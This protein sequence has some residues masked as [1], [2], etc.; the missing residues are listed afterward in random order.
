MIKRKEYIDYIKANEKRCKSDPQGLMDELKNKIGIEPY[1]SLKDYTPE[2]RESF[3]HSDG[4]I[5]ASNI[6]HI[7]D[8]ERCEDCNVKVERSE[9]RLHHITNDNY[10][11][12]YM[13]ELKTLCIPC[14]DKKLNSKNGNNGKR[15][16]VD[17]NKKPITMKESKV[18]NMCQEV[19][20][21]FEE[22][23]GK[24]VLAAVLSGELT[25]CEAYD[26]YLYAKFGEKRPDTPIGYYGA[27]HKALQGKGYKHDRSKQ[28]DNSKIAAKKSPAPKKA[29]PSNKGSN[30][31][32][33]EEL[34]DATVYLRRLGKI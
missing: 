33:A 30:R 15:P 3:Y 4:W 6:A 26:K 9:M 27:M 16:L 17:N 31:P 10:Y 34:I 13:N 32:S 25:P 5:C 21:Y 28:A 19:R 1:Q 12:L 20:N 22:E 14:H 23:E 11:G 8:D 24:S 2:K 18:M 29:E 7:R